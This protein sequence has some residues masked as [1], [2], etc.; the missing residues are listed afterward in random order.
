MLAPGDWEH[1]MVRFKDGK[2]IGVHLSAH[3]DGHSWAWETMEKMGERPV[4]YVATGSR[5]LYIEI[6]P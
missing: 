1:A 5:E 6:S 4:G 2:P 3:A